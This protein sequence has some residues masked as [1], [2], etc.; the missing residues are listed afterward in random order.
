MQNYLITGGWGTLGGELRDNLLASVPTKTEMNILDSTRLEQYVTKENVDA[1]LHLAAIS[2]SAAA[3]KDTRCS[4]EVNVHGTANIA[5]AAKKF[6]KK[7]IYISTD[8]VFPGTAGNYKETDEPNPSN[9]YGFT[10]YAGEL[11]IQSRTNNHLIIRTGF[12][13]SKW[14]F[15]SAYTNVKTSVDYVDVIA[16]EILLALSLNLSGILHIG[17]APKTLYELAR[18][19][20]PDIGAEEAPESF[21]KRKDLCIDKWKE[22]KKSCETNG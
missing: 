12:R 6:N 2:D 13:P 11:E 3:A 18:Q 22:I 20:N 16:K 19:R 15:R 8:Y 14:P 9:W 10:K 1:I 5:E 21:P 7:I 17:T 4:Y